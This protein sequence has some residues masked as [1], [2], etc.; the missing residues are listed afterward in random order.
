M[1][2]R[3]AVGVAIGMARRQGN[4][5]TRGELVGARLHPR[6]LTYLVESGVFVRPFPGV[7][8][9][10]GSADDPLVRIHAA[11][12]A[13]PPAGA[14]ASHGT[15]AWLQGIVERPPSEVHLAAEGAD[16]CR[17]DGVRLHRVSGDLPTLSYRGV[18]CTTPARTLL[19]L[20]AVSTSAQINRYVDRALEAGLVRVCDLAQ[21]KGRRGRAAL[22]RSLR[23]LGHLGAPG[24]SV[25][26]SE[27]HRLVTRYRLPVPKIQVETGPNGRYRVDCR[28]EEE[29]LTV[30][31]YGYTWHHSPEQMQHDLERQRQLTL[32]GETVLIFTWADVTRQPERLAREIRAALRR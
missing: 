26:E 21:D 17:L 13:V 28:Y 23:E 32:Q 14:V 24:A 5:A 10:A 11:I 31:L 29:R 16:H 4:V 9:V 3:D 6:H 8:V 18:R 25:L 7:F 30:E 12:A 2:Q 19:D 20:A 22:E 15:A 27:M 1:N